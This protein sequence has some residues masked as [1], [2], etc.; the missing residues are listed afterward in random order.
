VI[1]SQLVALTTVP[2]KAPRGTPVFNGG[3]FTLPYTAGSYGGYFSGAIDDPAD[4]VLYSI[5]S[6][7]PTLLSF[8]NGTDV[9]SSTPVYYNVNQTVNTPTTVTCTITTKDRYGAAGSSNS[10][11]VTIGTV[12]TQTATYFWDDVW[13]F[14]DLNISEAI[15]IVVGAGGGGGGGAPSSQNSPNALV[16]QAGSPGAPGFT[17]FA[18]LSGK[19]PITPITI[20]V[21]DGGS[22][23]VGGFAGGTS[24]VNG[25]A[26][27]QTTLT[28]AFLNITCSG[29]A[30]GT[31][32]HQTGFS[33]GSTDGNQGSL[34]ALPGLSTSYSASGAGWTID[35][36]SGGGV[37]Y[38]Q[39]QKLAY[40]TG[41]F[42]Q[43]GYEAENP[44][45]NSMAVSLYSLYAMTPSDFG[46][47]G[48]GGRGGNGFVGTP[49]EFYQGYDGAVGQSGAVFIRYTYLS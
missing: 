25:I 2:N 22:F 37:L 6:S 5:T 3:S 29:G 8:S 23:G 47:G 33:A 16:G 48:T 42:A 46:N 1:A 31:G 41:N 15:I 45:R 10:I 21:G 38:T 7:N 18:G 12:T 11:T 24:G 30:R 13:S 43:G 4:T 49:L 44:G 39:Y 20:N 28:S 36:S 27:Q 17:V 32:G 26:G 9:P 34:A 40:K 14:P 19:P 35:A